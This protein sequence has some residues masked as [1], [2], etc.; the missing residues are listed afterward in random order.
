MVFAQRRVPKNLKALEAFIKYYYP[1]NVCG[2]SISSEDETSFPYSN[3]QFVEDS[4]WMRVL[5]KYPSITLDNIKTHHS[6]IRTELSVQ[7]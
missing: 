3:S 4:K 6:L 2:V 1:N 5:E 7:Q